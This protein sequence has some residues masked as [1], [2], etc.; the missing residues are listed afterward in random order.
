MKIVVENTVCLNTGDAAIL[1]AIRHI[2][3]AVVGDDARS[4]RVV[5][6]RHARR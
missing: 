4:D 1:L 6:V 2:L 3:K 5:A